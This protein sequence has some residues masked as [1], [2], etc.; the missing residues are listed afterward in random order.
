MDHKHTKRVQHCGTTNKQYIDSLSIP[1]RMVI[2]KKA[3][4]Y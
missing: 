1:F 4:N 3:N 2:T